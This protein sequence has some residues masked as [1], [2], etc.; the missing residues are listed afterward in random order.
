MPCTVFRI[1]AAAATA[2]GRRAL[3]AI[4][5]CMGAVVTNSP[6]GPRAGR[7]VLALPVGQGESGR[8]RVKRS[9]TASACRAYCAPCRAGRLTLFRAARSPTWEARHVAQSCG[10]GLLHG[11]IWG[12]AAL[13]NKGQRSCVAR[14]PA[15]T[16]AWQPATSTSHS[17][18]ARTQRTPSWSHC[19]SRTQPRQLQCSVH[20]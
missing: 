14:A 8:A 16:R 15:G 9:L 12:C 1:A 3:A 6:H 17:T 5:A 7:A 19:T 11:S 18:S 13:A 10:N 4:A 20:R 2:T